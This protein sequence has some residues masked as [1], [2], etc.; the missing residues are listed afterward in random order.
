LVA[1]G[2]LEFCGWE[3]EIVWV[4]HAEPGMAPSEPFDCL[5]IIELIGGNSDKAGFFERGMN[6]V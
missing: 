4:D 3:I 6:R 1:K 5:K 2:C